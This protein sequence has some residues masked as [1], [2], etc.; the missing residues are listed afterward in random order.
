VSG[1]HSVSLIIRDRDGPQGFSGKEFL[2]GTDPF[3][4]N[5]SDLK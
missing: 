2:D 3:E 5:E 4:R 1:L